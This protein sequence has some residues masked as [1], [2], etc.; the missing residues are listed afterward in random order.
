MQPWSP[1][2]GPTFSGQAF[3]GSN[4]PGNQF[5]ALNSCF[6]FFIFG[7]ASQLACRLLVPRPGTEPRP[8]AVKACGSVTRPGCCMDVSGGPRL[9]QV[10]GRSLEC[11]LR[12]GPPLSSS[13]RGL[14]S[15]ESISYTRGSRVVNPELHRNHLFLRTL[16]AAYLFK[17]DL[18]FLCLF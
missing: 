13:V 6:H 1:H 5:P 3:Q 4:R 17:N 18:C 10:W 7:C 8:L 16:N 11:L 9:R 12:V 14:L 2:C 15:P